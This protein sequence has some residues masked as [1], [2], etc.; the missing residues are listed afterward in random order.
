MMLSWG[1][2]KYNVSIL[3]SRNWIYHKSVGQCGI[4]YFIGWKKI[5]FKFLVFLSISI[6]TVG[7]VDITR[8][9]FA[10][11]LAA[12]TNTERTTKEYMPIQLSGTCLSVH[13]SRL[14]QI[15]IEYLILFVKR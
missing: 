15:K 12:S 13:L 7:G 6:V 9:M 3:P 8:R 10:F 14:Y 4:G 1:H 2:I 5:N 11:E